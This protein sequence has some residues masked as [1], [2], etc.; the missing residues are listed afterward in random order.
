M[1]LTKNDFKS[2]SKIKSNDFND[3]FLG[4]FSLLTS[5]CVLAD[6]SSPKQGPK[7]LLPIMP[8]TDFVTQ[9]TKF[10]EPKLKDQLSNNQKS[11]YNI[12]EKVSGAGSKLAKG[13]FKW[14]VKKIPKINEEWIGKE[15]D[16][17]SGTLEVEKFLNYLQ[18]YDKSRKQT[19]TQMDL[20]KL[21]DKTMRYGQ[22]GAL[23]GKME[24]ILGTSKLVPIFE[25]RELAKVKG[26]DLGA[27]FGSY[28]DKVIEYHKQFAKRSVDVQEDTDM[29]Q[30]E[31]MQ[32]SRELR[33]K[34]E[35]GNRKGGK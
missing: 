4:F 3:E 5:Y 7:H 34:G 21:M 29:L 22:I 32:F 16:L 33:T 30:E 26:P 28:E 31:Q 11:L 6:F 1:I 25:F 19:I 10:I 2:F 15:E 24:P 12:V 8:R 18:G 17:K 35:E 9:Y 27:T 23:G 14:K 13:T 20:L